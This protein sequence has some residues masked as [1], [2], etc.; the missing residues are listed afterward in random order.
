MK[1]YLFPV[2]IFSI[3]LLTSCQKVIDVNLNDSDPHYI[4][5]GN[6]TDQAGP[7]TV[8]ISR[9]INFSDLNTFLR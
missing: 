8:R 9:S 6:V 1:R 7:Y 3:V 2:I 4:I 5:E